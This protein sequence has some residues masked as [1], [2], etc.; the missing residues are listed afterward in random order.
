MA[1]DETEEV[2]NTS[3]ENDEGG[4]GK[5]CKDPS[6]CNTP[7]NRRRFILRMKKRKP[8]PKP[9]PPPPPKG[10]YLIDNVRNLGSSNSFDPEGEDISNM[11]GKKSKSSYGR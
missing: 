4:N 5:G 9:V 2:D 1:I 7:S 8:K 3:E 6:G 10:K 11:A